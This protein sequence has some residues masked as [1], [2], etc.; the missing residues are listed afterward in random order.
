MDFNSDVFPQ[1]L[2]LR[3]PHFRGCRA[4]A[5]FTMLAGVVV[6]IS[7]FRLKPR[8]MTQSLREILFAGVFLLAATGAAPAVERPQTFCNPMD[9]PYRFQ[10]DSP[11]RREAADPTLVRFNGE[12]W[13]FASKSGGY[14]HSGDMIHWKFV[15]P[16]GLPL[17][18]YAPTVVVLNGRMIFTAF[19]TPAIFSTDDPLKGT[20]SKIADLKGYPDPDIFVND[21]GHVYLYYGCDS[22]GGIRVVEL[23]PGQKFKVVNGPVTC[24][25][26]DFTHHG[27]E[28]AGENNRGNPNADGSKQIAPWVEG[29]WMTKHAGTYYLQYSAPG[30]QFKTYA[31]GIY[32]ST[33]PMGPFVYA[34]YSPFSQKPTGF[35]SGAGH[36]SVV[37]DGG[38]H[39]W[40]VTTMT[41][42]VRHMFE[43]RLGLFPAG[44]T[45]DGQMFCNTYLGD[46]PQFV[47]GASKSPA[48]NNSP[49]WMLL[50]YRKSATASSALE[51]FP[52]KNA[53]DEDVRTWWSAASGK[54]G[55]WLQVDLGKSCRIEAMQINFA[56][57]G[58]TN[59][60]RMAGDFYQ[61]SVQVS[62]DG[63]LWKNAL[64]RSEN[65]RD[66][67]HDYAQLDAPVT[68]R[69]VRLINIHTPGGGLFSISGFRVFGNGLGRAPSPVNE[70]KAIRDVSD[71]RQA[72]VSW[73]PAQNADFYIIRYGV[74]PDRLFANYQ[75]YDATHFDINSLN[76]GTAYYLS[77]DAVND[78]GITDGKKVVPIK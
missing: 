23:D 52:V 38:V 58:A 61:Y 12:Y 11:N 9:L 40:H 63:T 69:Y 6:S 45:S 68:A 27:W 2:I 25:T 56:D 50:S 62:D 73:R 72:R 48:A 32:T 76:V 51:Q 26:A 8:L 67:P 39:L 46:Y 20:W 7:F 36:S 33:N 71:P 21:D 1:S 31:D 13:L 55:E 10:L 64:D 37:E 78:S 70:V 28:V 75:V 60:D 54:P 57:Q 18:D 53:L 15:E 66:S 59:R 14:W 34:P 41:I 30:T 19:G 4:G 42:S 49:G 16:S 17:E 44:F 43:R 29:A 74:A 5:H 77:V 22:N 65:H 47:P 24:F 3:H 35:I